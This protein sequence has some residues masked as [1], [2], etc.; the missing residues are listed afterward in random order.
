MNLGISEKSFDLI[1]SALSEWGEIESAAV[2]GSRAMGNYKRGSDIDLVIYGSEIKPEIVNELSVML[3]EKLPIP[4]Y[5]DVVHYESL[6]HEGLKRHI[7]TYGK[8]F[9]IS[10]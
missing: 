3:N 5:V 6:K 1:V 8:I 2:F 9:Y 10:K 7:D 4:Y